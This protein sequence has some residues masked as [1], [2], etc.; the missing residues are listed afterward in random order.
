MLR[1][2]RRDRLRTE[3]DKAYRDGLSAAVRLFDEWQSARDFDTVHAAPVDP[4]RVRE[5]FDTT[6]LMA[7]TVNTV[8]DLVLGD[9]VTYGEMD[10]PTAYQAL[11]EWFNLN[12]VDELSKE[13]LRDWL[14][15]GVL[16]PVI[17]EDAARNAAAWVNLWDTVKHP[18]ELK[19]ERGN[20]RNVVGIRLP[21]DQRQDVKADYFALRRNT[22]ARK[23][24]T[25]G[26]AGKLGV[27]PLGPAVNPAVAHARLLELR[28]RL[29]EIRGRLNAVYYA[30]ANSPD[31]LRAA[32]ERFRNMPRD[33]RLVTLWRDRQT[34]QSE[35]LEL[36]TAKAEGADA[37]ADIRAYVRAVAM[38]A[39]I[40]EH[41]LAIGDTGNRATAE[42][43]TEPMLRRM[44]GLQN[45]IVGV[46]TELF[47]KELK[48][49][50]GPDQVYQQTIVEVDGLK[51]NKRTVTVTADKLTVPFT[52]PP[53]RQTQTDLNRVTTALDKGLISKQTAT[54]ELGFDPALEAELMSA[55]A[56]GDGEGGGAFDED[57]QNQARILN[58]N[59]LARE[60]ND[61]DP[62]V[63]LHWAHI[64]TAPGA[65]TAP[66]AYLAAA[67]GTGSMPATEPEP[68]P[69]P[70]PQPEPEPDD[71]PTNDPVEPE[72]EPD[73]E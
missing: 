43:M 60:A 68:E 15:D 57:A 30:F 64:L 19:L 23:D 62:S 8:S 6:P 37:E 1:L 39:G 18:V 65:A 38:V 3:L 50:F 46:L 48:R 61:E 12:K 21:R 10:D 26:T 33:G 17:A 9:G 55:E 36:L 20:P 29:H 66:G 34:G 24:A 25:Q 42:S 11:E 13:M 7:A 31:E 70:G 35:Q 73:A 22:P 14:L 27:S 54:S 44:E 49:R 32:A 5:A 71:E 72:G 63:G 16:L 67:M 28:L 2:F 56:G 40:P 69:E 53:I 59:R 45:L 51:R 47:R 58:A 41:Y 4:S 52:A